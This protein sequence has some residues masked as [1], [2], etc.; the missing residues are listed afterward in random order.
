MIVRRIEAVRNARVRA[1]MYEIA[2][3]RGFGAEPT[4]GR[5]TDGDRNRPSS[6]VVPSE[7][8]QCRSSE[9]STSRELIERP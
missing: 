6:S 3:G 8:V 1:V 5:E 9:L 2:V 4:T 7:E